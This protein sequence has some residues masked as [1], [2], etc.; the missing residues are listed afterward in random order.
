MRDSKILRWLNSGEYLVNIDQT[1]T[2]IMKGAASSINEA[3]TASIFERELYYL[4]RTNTGISLNYSSERP[5]DGLTHKFSCLS[6]RT[7]GRGRLDA[8]INNLIIEYKHNSKLKT[9][10]QIKTASM[11]VEDYMKALYKNEKNKYNAILTDGIKISY[12]SGKFYG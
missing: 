5:V 7:S 1:R 9:V 11:Q 2:D 6:S 8:V 12:F 4:V 3:E 10:E